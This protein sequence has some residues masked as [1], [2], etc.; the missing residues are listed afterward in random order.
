M[1]N[2]E[3]KRGPRIGRIAEPCY[4]GRDLLGQKAFGLSIK[5]ILRQTKQYVAT[6]ASNARFPPRPGVSGQPVPQGHE[7]GARPVMEIDKRRRRR[8][9]QQGSA[10]R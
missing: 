3:P 4:R 5:R 8:P 6:S 2:Q 1:L 9:I 7:R 10:S